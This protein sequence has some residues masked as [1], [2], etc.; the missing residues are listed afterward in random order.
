M[1]TTNNNKSISLCSKYNNIYFVTEEE[2]C[3]NCYHSTFNDKTKEI[4]CAFPELQAKLKIRL[5]G[6]SKTQKVL[7]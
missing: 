2:K 1:S 7:L 6:Q 5:A 4:T 3:I